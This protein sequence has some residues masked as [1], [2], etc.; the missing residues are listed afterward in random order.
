MPRSWGR[1]FFCGKTTPALEKYIWLLS[2]L[3]SPE[4]NPE[5]KK[6]L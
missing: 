2:V 1:V 6:L 3:V 5:P 4:N